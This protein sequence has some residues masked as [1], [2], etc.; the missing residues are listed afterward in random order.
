MTQSERKELDLDN[1]GENLYGRS[2][3]DFDA[4]H[5]RGEGSWSD[6]WGRMSENTV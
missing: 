5:Q 6:K 1:G 2:V 4:I 3:K